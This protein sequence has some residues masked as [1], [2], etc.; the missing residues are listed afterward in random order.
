MSFPYHARKAECIKTE[1]MPSFLL[2]S[3]LITKAVI[4]LYTALSP[5][6]PSAVPPL[7]FPHQG[8]KKTTHSKR[9]AE[10]GCA[11]SMPIFLLF[12]LTSSHPA[13]F[14]KIYTGWSQ[15]FWKLL[16]VN[17]LQFSLTKQKG[18]QPSSPY[19]CT[20]AINNRA[21]TSSS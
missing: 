20:P 4:A 13:Q 14:P 7:H 21:R 6:M 15:R 8:D 12:K 18:A 17:L 16:Q 9:R 1:G 11:I 3:L 2:H 10:I 19:K 5:V